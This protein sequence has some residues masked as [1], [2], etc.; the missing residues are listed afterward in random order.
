MPRFAEN[1]SRL[2]ESFQAMASPP[3]GCG[4][5]LLAWTRATRLDHSP[6]TRTSDGQ[7]QPGRSPKGADVKRANVQPQFLRIRW[8]A[9]YHGHGDATF[10][11]ILCLPHRQEIALQYQSA[12]GCGELGDS[13]DLCNGREPRRV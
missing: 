6:E 4:D 8:E 5:W 12:R 10:E 13:C 11:A 1:T 2:R 3:S 7:I 9:A